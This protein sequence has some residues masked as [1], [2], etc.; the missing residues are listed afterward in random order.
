MLAPGTHPGKVRLT[1]TDLDRSVG[2]YQDVIGLRLHV[3][4][5]GTAAMGAGGEDLVVLDENPR[6]RPAGRTS[7]LYHFA[8]LHPSREEL[9]S[10]LQRLAARRTPMQGASD[11]GVSEALYLPDPD[12]NGIELYA[13]RP[14]EVWPPPS[15]G[16]RVGMFTA[17]LDLEE[18]LR[19]APGDEA[20]RHADQGLTLGH[21]HLH[22]GDLD[23]AMRFYRDVIGFDAMA[24][25]PGAAFVSAGGYH[26]HLGFNTWQG[27]G[28]PPAPADAVGL[29]Y[30]TLLLDGDDELAAARERVEAAGIAAEEHPEGLLVRDPFG[31]ALVLRT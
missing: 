18:L 1:V 6:A 29:R 15:P 31:N 12:G 22:V 19:A 25:L 3:R 11:H 28:A 21:V 7:G 13:D 26:H 5:N 27:E 2:F 10:A 8:L 23:A 17:P 24:E 30:W 9:A 14:R 4:E 16:L 20:P